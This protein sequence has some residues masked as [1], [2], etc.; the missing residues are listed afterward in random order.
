MK[1][2]AIDPGVTAGIAIYVDEKINTCVIKDPTELYD[3]IK[4]NPWDIVVYEDYAGTTISGAGLYTVRLIGSI[5]GICHILNKACIAQRPQSRLPY[6]RQAFNILGKS[7]QEHEADALAH[8]LKY[9][10]KNINVSSDN[11]P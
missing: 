11:N 7:H 4:L 3:L 9:M 10:E 5:I 1:I 2:L 8:L 6:I